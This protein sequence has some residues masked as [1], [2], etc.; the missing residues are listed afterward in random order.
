MKDHS[1]LGK[2]YSRDNPKDRRYLKGSYQRPRIHPAQLKPMPLG[3]RCNPLCPFFR[4]SKNAFVTVNKVVRGHVQKVAMCRLIG[5]QCLGHACQFA[6]CE[7]KAL[8]PNGRCAIAVKFKGS[9]DEF[10][11]EVE[12]ETLEESVTNLIKRKVGRREN[13]L[14]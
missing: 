1:S 12:R 13:F 14:E 8:L 11:K 6:Y 3:D 10:L 5:D 2:G 9:S 4:C 7:R